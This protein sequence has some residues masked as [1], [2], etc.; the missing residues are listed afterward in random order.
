MPDL[1]RRALRAALALLA[2]AL[3]A[4][5]CGK[6][7]DQAPSP[8]AGA[9]FKVGLVFDIG[10]RGDKSFN[11]A[12]YAGLERA[13]RELGVEF[14]PREREGADTSAD[15]SVAPAKR[16][17]FGSASCSPTIARWSRS[18]EQAVGGATTPCGLER[19]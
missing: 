2:L 16:S 13:Q 7:A 15:A 1:G 9:A 19:E 14:R 17:L 6:K 18:S 3:L 10:G 5:G 4:P 12:A 8:A 11:D